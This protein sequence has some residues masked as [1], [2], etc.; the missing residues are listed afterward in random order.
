[1]Y[2]LIVI[3]GGV[4]G[5][6]IARDAA[7]RGL[8]VCLLEKGDLAG[9]TSSASTKLIHGGLRYLEHYDFKLVADSLNERERLL[10]SAPHLIRPMEFILPHE[11]HLRPAWMIRAGL[12]LYD[13]LGKRTMLEGSKKVDLGEDI[14]GSP[15][16]KT[17]QTGFSYAD[18]R[19]DDARLVISCAM[20]A[21]DRGA[22]IRPRTE[23]TSLLVKADDFLWEVE[24]EDQ[25]TGK[26]ETLF[27][28]AVVNAAGPWVRQFLDY[29]ELATSQTYQTRF[30]KGSHIVLHKLY[31]GEHAYILQQPDGRIIFAI[32]FERE[33][34]LIG[35]T[36]ALYD[37]DPAEASISKEEIAYLCDAINRSF[38]K[39]ISPK[40][41]IWA[42]SGVRPLLDSGDENLSKVTRDYK[43]DLEEIFGPPLLNIFGGKLTTFRKL[44]TQA[45]DL[46][47][48]FFDHIK[49]AWT[50]RAVLPGGDLEDEDFTNFRARKQQE[51][52]WLPPQMIRRMARAYGTMIDDV[53]NNA[54][55]E[56]DLGEHYGDDVYECEIR[57]MIRNEWAY[58]LD[59]IIW[60][61]S[62][63]GLHTSYSTQ[64]SLKSALP[65]LIKELAS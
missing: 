65:K 55:S 38:E 10:N 27:A 16:K 45:V 43:L 20:D 28:K 44:S 64:M 19:T 62:K 39:P 46:L 37:G 36:D 23:C 56:T 18:C 9:A 42:Y 32:P 51:Y 15:L 63:L 25:I 24:A 11:P 1:M 50:D 3:G 33:F 61:R 58:T 41:V 30:S 35:T 40:D 57:H 13:H 60:R 31:D 47:A 2:D 34:T 22:D 5:V 59:D 29:N 4:N 48:P 54:A 21:R 14:T 17:Y 7:G 12:F 6:G 26:T 53:L 49:P 52:D 8:S